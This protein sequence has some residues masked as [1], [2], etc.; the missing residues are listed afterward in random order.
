MIQKEYYHLVTNKKM[1]KGQII[2]FDSNQKNSVYNHF[3]LKENIRN[4]KDVIQ[5]LKYYE[6]IKSHNLN[7]DDFNF[8]TNYIDQSVRTIRET[9]TE[10]VRLQNFAD[11]PSRLSCLYAART[12]DEL[13][14][15][16]KIFESYNREI[17]QLAKIKTNGS[18]FI[19]DASLLPKQ[20][21]KSF[22]YKIQEAIKY[23]KGNVDSVLPEVLIDGK[24]EVID[25]I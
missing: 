4:K 24:I 25:I 2:N 1:K 12:Y 11:R 14:E 20:D 8:V 10:M 7:N 16:K 15:W 13:L 19:G 23:W 9:I 6:D 17:L 21:T 18:V 5:T 3:F 22:D